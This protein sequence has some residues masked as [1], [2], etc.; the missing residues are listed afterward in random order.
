MSYATAAACSEWMK[1]TYPD[2]YMEEPSICAGED[3]MY[4]NTPFSSNFA[5]EPVSSRATVSLSETDSDSG[6]SYLMFDFDEDDLIHSLDPHVPSDYDDED[7]DNVAFPSHFVQEGDIPISLW[8]DD[9]L[10]F[11]SDEDDEEEV[12]TP[13]E[14]DPEVIEELRESLRNSV[15]LDPSAVEALMFESLAPLDETLRMSP[16]DCFADVCWESHPKLVSD[17]PSNNV[18][19]GVDVPEEALQPEWESYAVTSP[20]E[21][22][23]FSPPP[24]PVLK[25]PK[26]F[27][28]FAKH[29]RIDAFSRKRL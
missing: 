28:R 25:S 8:F 1:A 11:D 20:L 10:D 24:P 15:A 3:A 5:E 29:L 19:P 16:V 13:R 2:Y 26:G 17:A 6:R 12:Y 22:I 21:D 23:A 4:F 27:R 14:E 18:A 7:E 9:S